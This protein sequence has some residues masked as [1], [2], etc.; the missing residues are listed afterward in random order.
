MKKVAIVGGIRTPFTKAGVQYSDLSLV[1]LGAHVLRACLDRRFLLEHELD[2]VIMGTVL[3]DPRAPN[4]AREMVFKAG[5]PKQTRAHSVSNNCISGLLAAST[6]VD[7]ISSGRITSGIA[8][9]AESMSRPTLT[10]P[11]K[12]ERFFLKLSRA[13]TLSERLKIMSSFRPSMLMPRPPSPREPSTGLTMG[14]HCEITAQEL[15]ISRASQDARA[16]KSHKEATR[17]TKEGLF[18]DQIAP[19]QG[20]SIDTIMRGDTTIEKLAGLKPVFDK[21]PRGTITAGNASALTDGASAVCFMELEAAKT[22]GREVLAT[23]A[24]VEYAAIDPAHGL[25][26]APCLAVPALLSRMGLSIDD[27][28]LFEIHE[29]FGAQVEA[30]LKVFEQGWSRYPTLRPLGKIP[31]EKINVNGG[32]LALG[33]P[34]A[35]T[36]GR[37]ILSLAHELKRRN[38]KRGL[39]SVCAAGAMAC[40]VVIERP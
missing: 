9:G 20:V 23:V 3:L 11:S 22:R 13:R 1:D 16:Y 37:L 24:G 7:A 31:E 12:G 36:G 10:Y 21:G 2:E 26:M 5:L 25:L 30:N 18:V 14:E 6:L 27:I 15:T 33:H 19:L 17:A 39:I 34:F 4:W 32:S 35:A 29:A 28:D 8:G 40:A 38:A